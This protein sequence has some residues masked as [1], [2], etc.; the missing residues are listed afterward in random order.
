[1]NQQQDVLAYA[2]K[3]SFWDDLTAQQKEA[4]LMQ[5]KQVHLD[6]HD[7]LHETNEGCTGLI[8]VKNGRLR[9]YMNSENGRELTLF[10]LSPGNH[11]LVTATCVYHVMPMHVQI[12]AETDSDIFVMPVHVF[13][14]LNHHVVAVQ[15]FAA[16]LMANRLK[17]VMDVLQDSLFSRM[18]K[19]VA[20]YLWEQARAKNNLTIKTTHES[21]AQDL[22]T[23][24]EVVTRTLGDLHTR[25]VLLLS[26]GKVQIIDESALQHIL[27]N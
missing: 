10:H 5:V 23:A 16:T 26:R 7:H 18:D 13:D 11:C 25:G 24:R 8:T 20:A 15:N 9:A 4:L 12:Q 22:G 27:E 2:S 3:F 17:T 19:R 14:D 1:M 21:I 6:A